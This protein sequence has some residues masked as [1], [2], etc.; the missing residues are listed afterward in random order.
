[1]LF[2]KILVINAGSSSLKYQFFDM[3]NETA[4]LSG[5]IDGISLDRCV[6]KIKHSAYTIEVK[7]KIS[8]HVD[9]V[10][11]ALKSLKNY[12]VLRSFEEISAIGHR[13][14]HG[15]EYYSGPVVINELV[16]RR[17]KELSD[18]APLHN[19]P[20]IA[21]ILACRRMLPKVPQVAVFDTAFHQTMPKENYLYALP[22]EYYSK[23]K[24]RRYGFHGTSHQYV[25][26]QAQKL[27]GKKDSKIITCHLGNGDSITAVKN[28]KSFMTSMGFTPLEGLIMGTR[29][30]DIDPAI[31]FHLNSY[32]KMKMPQLNE[33]LNKKSGLLGI[34]GSTSDVRDLR[35]KELAGDSRARLALDMFVKR[36]AFYIAGYTALMDGVDAIVFTA[37][38]GEGGWFIRNRILNNLSFMGVRY[39]AKAN[40]K[41]HAIISSNDSKVKVF[42]IPTNEELQ[43]ARE[44]KELLK[45]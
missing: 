35:K 36:I 31:L 25:A 41:N 29:S 12:G 13:V 45:R 11:F 22:Y 17:I 7:Q 18:L 6:I 4:Q 20:S 28:G 40:R 39:D 42:V 37:G 10:M 44:T 24:I 30:G 8:D 2:L 43:I 26:R 5:H 9:A 34:S 1:V 27:F 23:Y 32:A 15:G 21:G 14:V 16:V 38:I 3:Q 19:P 33:L